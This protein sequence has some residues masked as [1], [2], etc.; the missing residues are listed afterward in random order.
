MSSIDNAITMKTV[1]EIMNKIAGMILSSKKIPQAI[2]IINEPR[3]FRKTVVDRATTTDT[4]FQDIESP[5]IEIKNP[6][7]RN[8]QIK[9]ISVIPDATF[10][11]AGRVKIFVNEVLLLEDTAVADW[12]DIIDYQ[13]DLEGGK[14]VEAGKSVKALI[15]TN[16]GAVFLTLVVTF[17]D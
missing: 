14:L 10:K 17:G 2:R 13:L 4:V 11:T 3:K 9:S 15:L 5:A 1:G 8:T 16:A 6:L 7:D 12:T